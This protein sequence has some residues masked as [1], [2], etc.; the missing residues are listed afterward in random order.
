MKI[1]RDTPNTRELG[2]PGV[3]VGLRPKEKFES[4]TIRCDMEPKGGYSNDSQPLVLLGTSTEP[5][6]VEHTEL[7]GGVPNVCLIHRLQPSLWSLCLVWEGRS[8]PLLA[9]FP[10]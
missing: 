3:S 10:K 5:A 6:L 4:Q 1:V 8:F 2:Y 9:T 7:L